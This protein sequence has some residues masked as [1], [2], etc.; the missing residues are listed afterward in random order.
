MSAVADTRTARG[1]TELSGP[2]TATTRTRPARQAADSTPVDA[3]GRPLSR[4]A[5]GNKRRPFV[6][7][8]A[9]L[10]VITPISW[11]LLHQPQNDEADASLPIGTRTDDSYATPTTKPVDAPTTPPKSPRTPPTATPTAPP[12]GTPSPSTTPTDTPT[13]R[14][15]KVP[16]TAPTSNPTTAP[17][18]PSTT[19]PQPTNTPTSDPTTTPPPP[20]PPDDNGGMKETELQ[21]FS[22]INSARVDNGCAP[23]KR[24]TSLTRSARAEAED[25]AANDTVNKGSTSSKATAGGDDWSASKAYDR[26][27]SKNRDV[28]LDCS[29]TTLGVGRGEH[30]Y[31]DCFLFVCSTHTRVGWVAT[32]R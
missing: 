5:R 10:L 1:T 13:T 11:I 24:D 22:K 9:V 32:F 30:D 16:T 2:R 31:P 21:L 18:P 7:V 27:M 3:D 20:P 6:A 15:T 8:A 28:V 12:T 26:M 29:L 4:A 19:D 14:S 25:R 23:L 17:P